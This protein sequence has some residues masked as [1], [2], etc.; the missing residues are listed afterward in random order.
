[1][2]EIE[3]EIL[4]ELENLTPFDAGVRVSPMDSLERWMFRHTKERAIEAVKRVLGKHARNLPVE[5]HGRCEGCDEPVPPGFYTCNG[6]GSHP[7][8]HNL[9]NGG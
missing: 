9:P 4:A 2:D 8:I 6:S 1:M 5:V 7:S 3:K